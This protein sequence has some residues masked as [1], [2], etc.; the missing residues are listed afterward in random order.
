[1]SDYY[2][3][4]EVDEPT[5]PGGCTIIGYINTK[6]PAISE[7]ARRGRCVIIPPKSQL[8]KKR[9]PVEWGVPEVSL[10][11]VKKIH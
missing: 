7:T 9:I 5:D 1:M 2:E 11:F 4:F 8:S 3:E 10:A 6:P